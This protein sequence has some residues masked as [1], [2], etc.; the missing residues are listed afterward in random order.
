MHFHLEGNF[1]RTRP[2]VGEPVPPLPVST[3]GLVSPH[4]TGIGSFLEFPVF[5]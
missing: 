3:V 2:R 4:F 1:V 5:L